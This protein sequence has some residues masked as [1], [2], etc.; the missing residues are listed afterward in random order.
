[1]NKFRVLSWNIWRTRKAGSLKGYLN[2]F[3]VIPL[4]KPCLEK[5]GEKLFQENGQ[6]LQVNEEGGKRGK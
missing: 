6:R 2:D 4:Q 5:E 1:M 3:D